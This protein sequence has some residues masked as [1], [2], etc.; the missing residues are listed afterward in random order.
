VPTTARTTAN[1][2]TVQGLYEA[3]GRGDVPAMLETL[4][5]DVSWE[6]WADWSPHRAGVPWLQPRTGKDGVAE[7]FGIVGQWEI[8]EFS[9]LDLMASD[10]Q[11]VAQIVIDAKLPSGSQYRDEE[12]H[13]WTFDEDGRVC[14]FRHYV[15]TAK[16]IAAAG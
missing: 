14:R 16:H 12:L 11:V 5:D 2:E 13:L 3:F 6:H 10:S 1:L 15:D 9:V 8:A 7:F 4:A